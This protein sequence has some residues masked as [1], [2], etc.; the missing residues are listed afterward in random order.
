MSI[1]SLKDNIESKGIDLELSDSEMEESRKRLLL[2]LNQEDNDQTLAMLIKDLVINR[3]PSARRLAEI[4]Y[5]EGHNSHG[6][7]YSGRDLKRWAAIELCELFT[8]IAI[9]KLFE[10][11]EPDYW[12]EY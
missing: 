8:D 6:D 11:S 2:F 10:N 1:Q 9:V 12:H 4:V 3:R 7:Q 5:P